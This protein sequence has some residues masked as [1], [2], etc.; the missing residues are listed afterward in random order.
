MGTNYNLNYFRRTGRSLSADMAMQAVE[1]IKAAWEAAT[2][3]ERA[4]F[5]AWSGIWEHCAPKPVSK[6]ELPGADEQLNA[7]LAG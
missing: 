2:N 7:K 6:A 1:R 5:M 3:D 4:E